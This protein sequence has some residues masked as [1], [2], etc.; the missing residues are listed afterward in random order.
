MGEGY[1]LYGQVFKKK[2]DSKRS[3]IYFKFIRL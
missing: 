1:E 3:T 2:S